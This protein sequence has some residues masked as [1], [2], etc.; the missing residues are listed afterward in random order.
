MNE[1]FTD[2]WHEN[3]NQEGCHFE[4]ASQA[5]LIQRLRST[6]DEHGLQAVKISA[7]DET[8]YE[9]AIGTWESFD[10]KTRACVAQINAHA[11]ETKRRPELRELAPRS[12]KPLV[13]SEVDGEGSKQH[14]HH[15]MTPALVLAENIIDD[16]RDLQPR[17]WVFWQA[18]ENENGMANS[19]INW[20]LI[21]ADLEGSSRAWSF[22]KKYFA[23]AQFSKFIRPGAVL[24][25][26]DR[27]N[28]IA[29]FDAKE[30][31]LVIVV[32]NPES[33]DESVAYDL[34]AFGEI[35]PSVKV[36]RT[37]AEEELAELPALSAAAGNLAAVAK[38]RSITTFVVKSSR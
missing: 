22:T 23:L 25:K 33:V 15:A 7:S 16:L 31:T 32:R 27:P 10:E 38:A 35:Q 21:H 19:N 30:R 3:G 4:R 28:A 36:Y 26:V 34:S 24:L 14:D 18:V 12:G 13:M 5:R 2:Y 11:Y 17:Q 1:P 20:G 37:S 6:L 29:A 9:R 8:N